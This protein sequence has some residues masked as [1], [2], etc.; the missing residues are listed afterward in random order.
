MPLR[1]S[2]RRLNHLLLAIAA[3]VGCAPAGLAADAIPTAARPVPRPQRALKGGRD[4]SWTARHE[5][6]VAEAGSGDPVDLIF[7]GD[8]IVQGWEAAGAEIWA[9][10]YQALHA[11]NLGISGDRTQHLLWRIQNGEVDGISPRVAVVL[12]GTNNT[13]EADPDE[14]AVGI[15]AI[16]DSL[17]SRLPTTSILLLALFPRGATPDDP[18]RLAVGEVNRRIAAFNDG[19]WI[20]FLDLGPQFLN[21]DGSPGPGLG[22][23]TIHLSPTGYARWADGMAATLDLLMRRS[24]GG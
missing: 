4:P 23:D 8:S 2:R 12:I 18:G 1:V 22:K 20:H 10:H 16:L 13:G 14:I 24:S 15:R 11:R 5:R 21:A 19:E 7:L 6:L 17:R 3:L 9:S